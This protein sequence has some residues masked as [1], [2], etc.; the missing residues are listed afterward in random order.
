MGGEG[1][2]VFVGGVW[3]RAGCLR[4]G[5]GLEIRDVDVDTGAC[6]GLM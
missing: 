2:V 4:V 5:G 3:W 6:D 1:F